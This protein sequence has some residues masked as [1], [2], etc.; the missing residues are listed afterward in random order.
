MS[1]RTPREELVK[2]K[3]ADWL[4]KSGFEV[5]WEKKNEW[6]FP[7]FHIVGNNKKPDLFIRLRYKPTW[8]QCAIEVKC[9]ADGAGIRSSR[10]ILDYYHDYTDNVNTYV[11]EGEILEPKYFLVAT[12]YSMDGHLFKFEGGER[13]LRK[14]STRNDAIGSGQLPGSEFAQTFGFVRDL[15]TQWKPRK[16]PVSVGALLSDKLDGGS[17]LPKLMCQTWKGRWNQAWVP[18]Y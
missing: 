15:W 2:K 9:G 11:I 1:S 4:I 8:Y 7:T 17:G 18:R 16:P 14:E 3:L 13:P 6:G 12:E 10:K 5:F